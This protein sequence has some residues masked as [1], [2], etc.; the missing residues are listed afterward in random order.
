[1]LTLLSP[2]M[3]SSIKLDIPVLDLDFM[4]RAYPVGWQVTPNVHDPT[5]KGLRILPCCIASGDGSLMVSLPLFTRT[6]RSCPPTLTMR[7][8]SLHLQY[9]TKVKDH[10]GI[11]AALRAAI[12]TSACARPLARLSILR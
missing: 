9:M 5:N 4:G 10:K 3:V 2:Q 8:L 11:D 6:I 7:R 12:V 1:M